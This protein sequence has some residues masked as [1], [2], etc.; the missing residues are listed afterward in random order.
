VGAVPALDELQ[1]VALVAAA[2]SEYPFYP[3]G[4]ARDALGVLVGVEHLLQYEFIYGYYDR[5][6]L[7]GVL[8]CVLMRMNKR[9][10]VLTYREQLKAC[11]GLETELS[12]LY[13]RHF[14]GVY[15]T[16]GL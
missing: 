11:Q 3:V 8:Q 10:G 9:C 6:R 4:L 2:E 5:A 15:P 14:A 7:Q 12:S 16:Q 13:D 1:C